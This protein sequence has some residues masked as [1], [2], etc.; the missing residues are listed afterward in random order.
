[1]NKEKKNDAEGPILHVNMASQDWF[2]F[3]EIQ[4]MFILSQVTGN[5]ES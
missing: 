2:C 1:M 4:E 5:P 3:I